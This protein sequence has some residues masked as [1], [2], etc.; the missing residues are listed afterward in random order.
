MSE[1]EQATEDEIQRV[2]QTV[3]TTPP[4]IDESTRAWLY[5][6]ELARIP[7]WITPDDPLPEIPA[8]LKP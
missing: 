4:Q 3:Y 1:S 7:R 6:K 2:L 8:W 5:R